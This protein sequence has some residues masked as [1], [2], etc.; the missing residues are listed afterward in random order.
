M[1]FEKKTI[2]FIYVIVETRYKVKLLL[3]Y[4]NLTVK[5]VNSNNK[6]TL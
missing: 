2:K 4:T 5:T 1:S 3:Y 6:N